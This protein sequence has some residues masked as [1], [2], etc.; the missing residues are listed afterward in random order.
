MWVVFWGLVMFWNIS[1]HVRRQEEGFDDYCSVTSFT[2]KW[3]LWA[4]L[5]AA[6]WMVVLCFSIASRY[7]RRWSEWALLPVR[8]PV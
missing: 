3:Y 1:R 2:E 6:I 5:W 4:S 8:P 7:N